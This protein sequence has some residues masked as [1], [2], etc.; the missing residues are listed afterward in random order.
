LNDLMIVS[1][2]MQVYL[3][4]KRL[5]LVLRFRIIKLFSAVMINV[6]N[7]KLFVLFC[8]GAPMCAGSHTV[9]R[10]LPERLF[11][12]VTILNVEIDLREQS[13]FMDR[14]D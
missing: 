6:V 2:P 9:N 11:C 14:R 3:R 7:D 8:R 5:H 13:F 10:V 1:P 4:P 12:E